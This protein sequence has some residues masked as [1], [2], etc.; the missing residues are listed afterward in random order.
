MAQKAA[1][2]VLLCVGVAA[3]AAAV[4]SLRN[5]GPPR[6]RR[7]LLA[8]HGRSD[9]EPEDAEDEHAARADARAVWPELAEGA[10]CWRACWRA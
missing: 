8:P 6:A 10:S 2:P 7:P 9:A 3:L 5:A 4:A 1:T